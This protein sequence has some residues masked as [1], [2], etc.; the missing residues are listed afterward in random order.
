MCVRRDKLVQT[1]DWYID[2]DG[3]RLTSQNFAL[4]RPILHS[5]VIC[6]VDHGMILTEANSQLVYLRALEATSTVR[7]SCH[8]RHLWCEWESGRMECEFSLSVPWDLKRSLT[9]RKISRHGS[10]SFA[11]QPKEGELRTFIALKNPSLWPGSNPQPLGPVA[12]TLSTTPPRRVVE[13][14][15]W[16]NRYVGV[17]LCLGRWK[18]RCLSDT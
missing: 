17:R 10:S 9:Y 13:K 1:V 4:Y 12:S 3:V 2:S 7:R 8:P 11:S 5:R 6:D 15:K 16:A 18:R 14:V